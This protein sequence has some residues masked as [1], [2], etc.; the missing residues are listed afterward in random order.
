MK[1]KTIKDKKNLS[2]KKVLLR[3]DLNVPIKDGKIEDDYKIMKQLPTIQY[4]LEKNAKIILLTHLGRPKPGENNNHL[5]VK[6]ISKKLSRVLRK[7]IKFVP[8]CVGFEAGTAVTNMQN[9]DIL[10]L[11]NIRFEEGEKKNDKTL[12]KNLAKLADV[13]VNNAF[14][15][16]HRSQASVDAIKSYIPSYAGL[17]LGDEVKHLRKALVK[18]EKPL[19]VI[20]GGSKIATK[21]NLIN[22]F[23]RSAHKILIGGAL[24]NNFFVSHN[25]E[26]GKSLI[27]KETIEFAKSFNNKKLLLP[28][29]VVVNNRVDG[30]RL[31]VRKV[32]E[33]KKS[34]CIYDIGPDT[35]K[36]YSGFIK[37]AKTLIWNGPLGMFEEKRYSNGTLAIARLMATVSKGTAYGVAGGGETVEALKMTKMMNHVD[38]VSTGGGAMLSYLGGEKMPG[39]RKIAK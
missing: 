5:S 29:D 10:M 17:L 36:L 14:A 3:V 38:W 27:D 12:A 2:G 28:I 25:L 9:G 37:S 34:D 39:L 19:I 35:I 33:V 7:S 16:S 23:N 1:V 18:P 21:I 13:Y 30:D 8:D 6:P 20:I 11:E 15:V 31:R 26:V 32:T 24:A 22:Q 4:L